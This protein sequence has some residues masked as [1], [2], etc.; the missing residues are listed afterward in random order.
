MDTKEVKEALALEECKKVIELMGEIGVKAN[1]INWRLVA[2][3]LGDIDSAEK[4]ELITTILRKVL[5]GL[6]VIISA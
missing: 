3:E 1:T 4:K 2:E 6:L 5:A